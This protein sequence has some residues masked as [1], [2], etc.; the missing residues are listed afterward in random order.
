MA[1]MKKW[2]IRAYRCQQKDSVKH[3]TRMGKESTYGD[4]GDGGKV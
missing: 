1:S 3:V 4:V 2:A